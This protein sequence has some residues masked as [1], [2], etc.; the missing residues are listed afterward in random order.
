MRIIR[1]GSK[2]PAFNPYRIIDDPELLNV[3]E[4]FSQSDRRIY[5]MTHFNTPREL[6][7]VSRKGLALLQKAGVMLANQTPILR[8]IN[9]HPY[10]LMELMNELSFMGV[11][12][13]YFFQCR[14][15]IGNFPFSLSLTEAY[16]AL[17]KA[18][19]HVSGLAKRARLVMSH[20]SGKIEMVGLN[21]EYIY[22]RYHR[23]RSR[24]DESQF[25]VY[26]R[27]DEAHWLDDLTPAE[28]VYRPDGTYD[29]SDLGE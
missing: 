3:L 15:T 19:A 6:T 22:L 20:E 25:L 9:D 24:G 16:E 14:P 5:V 2:M 8:G 12:P 17:A 21:D 1:I 29:G 26:E 23:A 10:E 13:Y 11:T 7:P 4:R 28:H 27:D 18:K